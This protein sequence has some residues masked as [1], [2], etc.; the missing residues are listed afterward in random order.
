MPGIT[1]DTVGVPTNMVYF[2]TTAPAERWKSLLE[3][4]HKIL[5]NTT[6]THRIRFVTHLDVDTEDIDL[7]LDA[8][9]DVSRQMD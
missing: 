3:E 5:C 8:L 1:L 4:R 9:R 2:T 6:T 7:A